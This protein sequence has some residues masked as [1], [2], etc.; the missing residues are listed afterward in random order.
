MSFIT[1]F[2]PTY[3]LIDKRK[4]TIVPIEIKGDPT[5]NLLPFR[6]SC[7]ISDRVGKS[8]T[9]S[10]TLVL[11]SDDGIFMTNGPILTD[12]FAKFRYLIDVQFFQPKDIGLVTQDNL[13]YVGRKFRCEIANATKDTSKGR[14]V[15]VELAAYDI[16]LEEVL[17][18]E[19]HELFTPKGTFID[20]V[21]NTDTR[22]PDDPIPPATGTLTIVSGNIDS[23]TVTDG[24]RGYQIPPDAIIT[25]DGTGATAETEV[26]D[27]KVSAIIITNPGDANYTNAT[28]TIEAPPEGAYF[29]I[30]DSGDTVI[31][32]PDEER[33]QQDWIPTKP[34][35]TKELLDEIIEKTSRPEKIG[36]ENR[37]YFHFTV[38][39]DVDPQKFIVTAKQFGETDSGVTLQDTDTDSESQ[40]IEK[41]K[42]SD[43]NNR[44]YKSVMVG[45]GK[46]ASQTFPQNFGKLSSDLLHARFA[47]DYDAF[48]TYEKNDYVKSGFDRFKSLVEGNIGNTPAASPF[49]WKNLSTSTDG[50][51]WTIDEE[52]W[53]ANMAGYELN[54]MEANTGTGAVL[55]PVIKNGKVTGG[56]IT[57]GGTGHTTGDPLTITGTG[58]DATGTVIASGGTITGVNITNEGKDWYVGFFTDMNI[59]RGNYDRNDQFNEFEK[60]SIKDVESRQLNDPVDIPTDELADGKRWL[61]NGSGAGD[62]AGQLNTIAQYDTSVNP[63]VWRFSN[64]PQFIAGSPPTED[65]VNVL[66]EANIVGFNGTFWAVVWNIDNQSDTPSP[67][68]PVESVDKVA[69]RNNLNQAVEFTFNWNIFDLSTITGIILEG[70]KVSLPVGVPLTLFGV[71]LSSITDSTTEGQFLALIGKT[72][73]DL[74]DAFGEGNERNRASR[75]LM[76][77]IKCPWPKK[78]ITTQVKTYDVGELIKKSLIDFENLTE[79]IDKGIK[80]WNQGDETQNFGNLRG[81]EWW[82]KPRLQDKNGDPVNGLADMPFILCFRD[83]F[84]TIVYKI[85]NQRSHDRWNKF[86]IAAGP[87]AQMQ[88]FD[89]RVDELFNLLGF[90][91]PDNFF[92]EQR[93]LTGVKFD[94]RRVKEVFCVYKGSYDD[95]FFY[96]A[97][98]GA[99]YDS[100]I[101]H[102]TQFFKD[103]AV[104]FSLSNATGLLDEFTAV[105]DKGKIAVD[106]IHFIKDAYISSSDEADPDSRA[107]LT[108]LQ[109]QSDYVNMKDTLLPRVLSRK[110]FHP[111][112]QITDCIGN[113]RLRAGQSY[114]LND[115]TVTE[116]TILTPIEVIHIDDGNAYHC[117]LTSVMKYEDNG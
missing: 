60:I 80:G 51:P 15:S 70:I 10:G 105:V 102:V 62:W 44:K 50:T 73:Q 58:I 36:S 85:I 40:T 72:D 91:F 4:N 52:L 14:H 46:T 25:G 28:I 117:Q 93:E 32:L 21:N 43:F 71:D 110:K 103:L 19:R 31:E 108:D 1:Q 26:T 23:G 74:I 35:P 6:S 12:E 114:T 29:I 22:N 116:P 112:F 65:L 100:F 106:D 101:E 66:D 16:R 54:K 7:K 95:N 17:D 48:T 3:T 9:Y 30:E 79:T 47:S 90:T 99:Y 107:Q 83:K 75:T 45:R 27:G 81:L 39:D 24:S 33:L 67:F 57:F 82:Q 37:D 76:W 2:T 61:I 20:R 88:I 34:K 13:G 97:A 8:G 41:V 113:V 77:G 53:I 59:A 64:A 115:S 109:N 69:N 96:K 111:E 38:A 89:S 55:R 98:Q 94:W 11:R 49:A 18:A 78:P 87:E 5:G 42:Q 68:H 86:R 104:R 56:R 92:L 63:P 84:D